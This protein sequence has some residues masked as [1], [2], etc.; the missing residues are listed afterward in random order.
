MAAEVEPASTKPNCIFLNEDQVAARWGVSKSTVQRV[1]RAKRV[2]SK[3]IGGRWKFRLDWLTEFEDQ[4][5]S[6]C[7]RSSA[8]IGRYFLSKRPNSASWC[9]SRFDPTT[10]QTKRASLGTSDLQK[11]QLAL[12]RYVTEHDTLCR[13]EPNIVPFEFVLIR[14][15]EGHAKSIRSAEQARI[16]M[17]LWSDHFPGAN[18]SGVTPHRQREFISRMRERGYR[19]SYISRVLSVGRAALRWA[20]KQGEL[21]SVPFILDVPRDPDVE[22][23]R[24]RV[25]EMEEVA[26]LFAETAR[27]PHLLKFCIISLN[28]LARPEAVL[29]LGP[30]QV[31]L[32]RR[33]LNLNP[34]GGSKQKNTDRQ[35]QSPR[36]CYRGYRIA[37][38]LGSF[39]TGTNLSWSWET[40]SNEPSSERA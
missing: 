10:R 28:T 14:Y 27:T 3:L 6:Q 21:E 15:W 17:G 11:A 2:R 32:N 36:R 1:R 18:V 33:L 38:V 5:D 24:Y 20:W 29:E 13:A 8:E 22:A 26:R 31:D 12:A 4:V 19:E 23:E 37:K 7:Q 35:C 16:S 40:Y 30:S 39:C 9:A 25:L 34:R